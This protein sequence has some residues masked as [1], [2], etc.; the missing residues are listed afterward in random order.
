MKDGNEKNK[1]NPYD[2]EC[3]GAA[4]HTVRELPAAALQEG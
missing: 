1:K 4:S 2:L 3:L